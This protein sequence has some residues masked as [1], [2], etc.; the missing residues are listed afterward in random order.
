MLMAYHWEN[1][2]RRLLK[3]AHAKCR[4]QIPPTTLRAQL[5]ALLESWVNEGRPPTTSN[6]F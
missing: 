4:R 1:I 6:G 5:I 3:D 2:P